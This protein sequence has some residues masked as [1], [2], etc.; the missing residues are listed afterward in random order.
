M[1]RSKWTGE[2]RREESHPTSRYSH[3]TS[4]VLRRGTVLLQTATFWPVRNNSR[5]RAD[6]GG[7]RSMPTRSEMMFSAAG[8]PTFRTFEV[9]QPL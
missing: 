5:G 8:R 1:V 2:W 3:S 4:P 9:L 7:S 6:L